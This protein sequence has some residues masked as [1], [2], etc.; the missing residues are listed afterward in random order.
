MSAPHF[1]ALAGAALL[2][3]LPACGEAPVE[4]RYDA[5]TGEAFPDRREP[6]AVPPGGLG[7]VTDSLSDTL[8]L[9]DLGTGARIGHVP[10]G[11]DPVGLDGP[12]HI[13]VD[14]TGGFVYIGLS[15]PVVATGGPHASHGSS[16]QPGYVQKLALDDFRILGQVRV[17]ANPGE[18]VASD[19]GRR[20]VVSH[21][22][23]Q[24][25]I[26]NAGNLDKAR[27][28]IALVDPE[29]V[30]LTGSADPPRITTCVA[31]HGMALSRP[32]GARA[33][34]ACYGEDSVAVVDLDKRE[35]L[36]RIPVD[37]AGGSIG[38]PQYGPY[39]AILSP[40]GKTLA[41]GNTVSKDVRFFDIEANAMDP[42]RQIDT[43]GAPFF[44]AFSA[45]GKRLWIPMQ[46]PD[47]L[48]LWDLENNQEITRRDFMGD[49]CKW[50]HVVDRLD[51]TR[52][53]LICEGDHVATGKILVLDA[54][55]LATKSEAIAGVYPDGIAQIPGAGP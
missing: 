2:F 4:Y 47:A 7:I 45:D 38:D 51:D 1:R 22:D 23:L 29:G 9:V 49:E 5:Y 30:L 14:R 19:D 36:D 25:A 20:V 53:I 6:V 52:M 28:T 55:T 46:S 37:A 31:P 13:A 27:A 24:R 34:V 48:V 8:S 43:L 11:R 3:A 39:S 15:Y 35:V 33:Y 54:E 40:D 42:D 10:V 18:I 41:L 16:V 12:H 50:P 21:Y 32:D 44:P 17:D 26:K